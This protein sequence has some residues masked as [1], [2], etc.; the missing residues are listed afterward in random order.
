MKEIA[1]FLNEEIE[2][3]VLEVVLEV[4]EIEFDLVGEDWGGGDL[5]VYSIEDRG[6]V[7][8][9]VKYK[10]KEDKEDWEYFREGVEESCELEIYYLYENNKLMKVVD[11]G[12]LE[13]VK[14]N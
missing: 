9:G 3:I 10:D 1:K 5:L 8:I 7:E 11:N 2:K 6:G 12:V 13:E 4:E 14:L